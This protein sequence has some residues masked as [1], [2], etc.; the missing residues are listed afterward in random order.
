MPDGIRHGWNGTDTTDFLQPLEPALGGGR[1]SA[2]ETLTSDGGRGKASGD[3]VS[4]ELCGAA[5]LL[6]AGSP[7][8]SEQT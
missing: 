7:I 2:G 5:A 4:W 8:W 6:P 1:G 3:Q